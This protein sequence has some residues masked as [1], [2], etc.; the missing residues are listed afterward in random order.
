MVSGNTCPTP[1]RFK[2]A[3]IMP[4]GFGGLDK[5]A[6][7]GAGTI[8]STAAG[9]TCVIAC[10]RAGGGSGAAA[11]AEKAREAVASLSSSIRRKAARE[12]S[13][14]TDTKTT[15]WAA[16][17]RWTHSRPLDEPVGSPRSGVST[18]EF[19][20]PTRLLPPCTGLASQRKPKPYKG[21][22]SRLWSA[23]P[24]DPEWWGSPSGPPVLDP[25]PG[26]SMSGLPFG[27]GGTGV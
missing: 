15:D 4:M 6:S 18:A 21:P 3:A 12:S 16:G 9:S 24:T 1:V 7:L 25:R 13:S 23:S 20:G 8:D 5:C 27:R 26:K 14:P 11:T 22:G 10:K 17:S 19:A 2:P